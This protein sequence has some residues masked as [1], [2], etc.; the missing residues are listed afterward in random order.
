MVSKREHPLL[1]L[2]RG[3]RDRLSPG[4]DA[5]SDRLRELLERMA[6]AGPLSSGSDGGESRPGEY[7]SGA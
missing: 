6:E 5:P 1:D 2:G 3:L 4:L 7:G